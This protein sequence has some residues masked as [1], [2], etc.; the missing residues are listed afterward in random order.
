MMKRFL[1]SY[2]KDRNL[3]RFQQNPCPGETMHCTLLNQSQ[4]SFWLNSISTWKFIDN[5]PSWAST[6]QCAT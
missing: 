5:E 2:S 6:W 4:R 3:F 1:S